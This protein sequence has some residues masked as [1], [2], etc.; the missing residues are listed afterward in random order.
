MPVSVVFN[1]IAVNALNENGTITTG[2]NNQPDWTW[3]GKNNNA[4]GITVGFFIA[5]NNVNTIFDNDVTDS[6]FFVP[7]ANNPQPNVQY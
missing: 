2:Q 6:P 1:Q 3:Q 7:T 4:A 5:A